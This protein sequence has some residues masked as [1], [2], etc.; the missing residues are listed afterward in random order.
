MRSMI[1]LY[2]YACKYFTVLTLYG[3]LVVNEI[4]PRDNK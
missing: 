4:S 1:V 3:A 2:F